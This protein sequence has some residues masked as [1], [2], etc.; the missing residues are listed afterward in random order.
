VKL[1][2]RHK[3]QIYLR[4]QFNKMGADAC[5]ILTGGERPHLGA[6]A[7]GQVRE[8]LAIPGQYSSS[9]SNITLLGHKEDV[10]AREIAAR[11]AVAFGANVVVCCGIHTDNIALEDI[12][13]IETMSMDMV[14]ELIKYIIT[15]DEE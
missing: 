14:E 8:S 4:L 9:I 1:I 2:E 6:V 11:V 5:L 7:V 10:L 13:E 15:K 3:G 12:K